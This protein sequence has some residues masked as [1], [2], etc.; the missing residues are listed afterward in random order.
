MSHCKFSTL[1]SEHPTVLSFCP[2]NTLNLDKVCKTKPTV[3]LHQSLHPQSRSPVKAGLPDCF[4]KFWYGTQNLKN[5]VLKDLWCLPKSEMGIR[6]GCMCPWMCVCYF[7]SFNTAIFLD[8]RNVINV[9][10]FYDGH[11]RVLQIN[12]TFIQ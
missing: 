2:C 10:A 11:T 6:I 3:P 7:L 5:E 9:K 8:T 4:R 12:T 1:S